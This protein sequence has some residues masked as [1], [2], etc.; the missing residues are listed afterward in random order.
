MSRDN[1]D[2]NASQDNEYDILLPEIVSKSFLV[3][4]RL[5]PLK[6]WL[7][8]ILMIANQNYIHKEDRIKLKQIISNIFN[9]ISD[10]PKKRCRED[11]EPGVDEDDES[12]HR[13]FFK[14]FCD[15]VSDARIKIKK[16]PPT[17]TD[18][19]DDSDQETF[20]PD[21]YMSAAED[22]DLENDNSQ[23]QS[24]VTVKN[25]HGY[26][27]RCPEI[28]CRFHEMG[29]PSSRLAAHVS[30]VHPGITY[31]IR[32]LERIEEQKKP[33]E[34]GHDTDL[35]QTQSKV[36]VKRFRKYRRGYF[37]RCPE[38]SCQFH[39]TGISSRHLSTHV[40]SVHPEINYDISTM[41]RIEQVEQPKKA[42]EDSHDTDL[43]N[44]DS[45]SQ[46][47][48][49]VKKPQ[50]YRRGHFYRCPEISCQFHETGISSRH[51][52]THVGRVHPEINYDIR[53]LERIE[54]EEET[55]AR[56]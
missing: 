53:Q 55:T 30:R 43:E 24:E 32:T 23:S 38:T 52:S 16:L 33:V 11:Q 50:S 18:V 45:Q 39:K 26:V 29:I 1:T 51:L 48:V 35:N 34:D 47:E 5:K 14:S 22:S 31:D 28:G 25:R 27:Y 20:V 8:D 41:E 12:K 46:P 44:D 13:K 3:Q 6:K 54:R 40:R 9:F 15:S 4:D 49:A 21:D 36:A 37:Y 19:Q 7:I 10:G 56:R 42:V 17:M 2:L